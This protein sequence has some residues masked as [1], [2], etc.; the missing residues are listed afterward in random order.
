MISARARI[1]A[2][3]A[4]LGLT[5]ALVGACN[6]NSSPAASTGAGA[7]SGGGTGGNAVAIVDF[8]FNPTTITVKA[9]DTVTWT[10]TGSTA[11]TVTA[12]DGSFDSGNLNGGATFNHTFATA[13]TFTYHC[14]IHSSM[15]A[16]VTVTQ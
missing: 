16:T 2:F 1:P 9:G 7:S 6:S 3:V 4:A 15:K 11:H 14:S 5:I 12:D 13:G 10:N 8:A